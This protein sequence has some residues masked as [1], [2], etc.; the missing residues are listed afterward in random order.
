MTSTQLYRI[1]F[2]S[3]LVHQ[4]RY[5]LQYSLNDEIFDWLKEVAGPGSR[6]YQGSM[7]WGDVWWWDWENLH[8]LHGSR[9][10][11]FDPR[12]AM[13]FKLTWVGCEDTL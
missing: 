5:T 2:D 10:N 6:V 11:T 8:L 3:S 13:L 7:Y 4:N 12:I 9:F 1:P